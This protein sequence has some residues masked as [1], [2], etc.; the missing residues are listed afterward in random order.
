M[1][2]FFLQE[3]Q[4]EEK[5]RW[6]RRALQLARMGSA[7]VAPNPLVGCVLVHPEK[8]LI[9]EGWHR[10][11]G[12]SHA[13]V[14]AIASVQNPKLISG[15]TAILNLEPCAHFGK[16]PPCAELL[17]EKK[18]ARVIISNTD[19]N[20]LVSGNGI[21]MLEKA[22]ISVECGVL[23]NE[24]RDLNRFFFL[25]QEKKRPFVCLKW[26]QSADGFI[27]GEM[28]K[29]VWISSS[30]SRLMVHKMRSEYQAIM[31]GRNTLRTDNPLL[32][33]RDWPGRQP[34]RVI[35]DPHLNLSKELR[36]FHDRTAPVWI[37]NEK[38]NSEE[39]H[40]RYI[41]IRD[42]D[43]LHI[44]LSFL[45]KEGIQSLMVEGGNYLLSR[46]MEAGLWDE[47]VIFQAPEK[48]TTG[49]PAPPLPP[50]Q[51]LKTQSFSGIDLLSRYS[52]FQ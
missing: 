28:G 5:I 1:K 6:M 13:E 18:V 24:G 12:K 3:M 17:I 32:N 34:V 26:A 44:M 7:A 20:P 42:T 52:T 31:T 15:S 9:G 19:P 39:G 22:G 27:A 50:A 33:L 10:E 2:S 25:A 21:A 46:F 45:W 8:G 23:E 29:Q 4:E 37:L 43:N 48:L 16:T 51:F 47:A 41:C 40:I 30:Q 35:S 49:I 11:F 38:L 14:N 36:I